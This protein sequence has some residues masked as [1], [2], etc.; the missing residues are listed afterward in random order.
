MNLESLD[1][2]ERKAYLH[3]K[4][5]LPNMVKS[6]RK[7]GQLRSALKEA[8]ETA[9]EEM[10]NLQEQLTRGRSTSDYLANLQM[11]NEARRYAEEIVLPRYIL[12]P[13]ESQETTE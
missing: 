8:V 6:L 13:P 10:L 3:W 9:D 2:L 7:K 5:H 4:E 11:L 1:P 12:L